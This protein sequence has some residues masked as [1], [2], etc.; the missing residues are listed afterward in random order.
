M[1][2][3]HIDDPDAEARLARFGRLPERIRF[4]DMTEEVAPE[5]GAGSGPGYDPDGSFRFYNCLA[6][7]FGL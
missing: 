1:S 4:E 6:V 3:E 2:G 5:P 7:D